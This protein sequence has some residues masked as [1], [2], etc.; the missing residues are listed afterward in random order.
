M[1]EIVKVES[2]VP[3]GHA[4][5]VRLVLSNLDLKK[6]AAHDQ[7]EQH[8]LAWETVRK[9][10][11]PFFFQGTGF[12]GYLLGRCDNPQQALETVLAINQHILDSIARF[13]RFEY[14]FRSKLMKTLTREY[15]D[16]KFIHI[17]SAYLGAELARLRAQMVGNHEAESFQARTYNLIRVLPPMIYRHTSGDVL[18]SYAVGSAEAESDGKLTV[19]LRT[20]NPSQQ[21]AWLVAENIGEFGHPLVRKLLDQV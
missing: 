11:N 9:Q 18:Q 19:S 2:E 15:Y 16:P 5:H 21:D 3:F 17:W 6:V 20:L 14:N 4:L 8:Y 13:Y 7:M 10:V 1:S 12:E